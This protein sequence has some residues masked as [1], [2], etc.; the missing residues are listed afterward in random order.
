VDASG[1]LATP[2]LPAEAGTIGNPPLLACYLASNPQGPFF[3]L[4][5]G[6]TS[7]A[8]CMLIQA[9]GGLY[10]AIVGAQPGWT[11]TFVIVY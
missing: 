2:Y 5:P 7:G 8:T 1:V 4:A 10:A 9:G 3:P 6:L 11:G